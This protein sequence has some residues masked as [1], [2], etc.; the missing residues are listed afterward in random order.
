MD[1]CLKTA[2]R[3]MNRQAVRIAFLTDVHICP[4]PLPNGKLKRHSALQ[5]QKSRL[6]YGKQLLWKSFMSLPAYV[7][8]FFSA[9]YQVGT[10][11]LDG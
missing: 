3:G 1:V 2:V 8:G 4:Q 7:I 10:I 6:R 5:R 9:T 11:L